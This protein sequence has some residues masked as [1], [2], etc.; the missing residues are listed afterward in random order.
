MDS[1]VSR[2]ISDT[3]KC[4]LSPLLPKK[5]RGGKQCSFLQCLKCLDLLRLV[6]LCDAPLQLRNCLVLGKMNFHH[7]FLCLLFTSAWHII[8]C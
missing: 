4:N 5:E 1:L 3:E 2:R 7:A 8:T 6:V